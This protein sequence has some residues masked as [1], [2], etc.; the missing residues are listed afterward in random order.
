MRD[1]IVEWRRAALPLANICRM[2]LQIGQTQ[3]LTH[4]LTTR[5]RGLRHIHADEL[6]LRVGQRQ[7]EQLQ[8]ITATYFQ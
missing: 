8:A 2:Q 1:D 5:N 3:L 6:C 4:R 7:A